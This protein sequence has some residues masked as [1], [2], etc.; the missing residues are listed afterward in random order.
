MHSKKKKKKKKLCCMLALHHRKERLYL[1]SRRVMVASP[2]CFERKTR[3]G[4]AYS[5]FDSEKTSCFR[6]LF[7]WA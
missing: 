7:Q 5:Y 1:A 6:D 2:P 4:E 3:S